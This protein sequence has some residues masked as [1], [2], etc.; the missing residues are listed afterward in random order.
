MSISSARLVTHGETARGRSAS[1]DVDEAPLCLLNLKA[2][3]SDYFK[4]VDTGADFLRSFDDSDRLRGSDMT[5]TFQMSN[6]ES[7]DIDERAHS[8][9]EADVLEA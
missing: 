9:K 2:K 8:M 3:T 4:T 5:V 7:D 6:S 1:A